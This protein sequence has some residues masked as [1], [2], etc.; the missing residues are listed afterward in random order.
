M[1]A[2][3]RRGKPLKPRV[4]YVFRTPPGVKIGR[5]PFDESVRRALEAQHPGIVFDWEKLSN[6]P[7]PSPDV[8][9]WRERRRIEKA[10]KQ[11]RREEELADAVAAGAPE[12][13]TEASADTLNVSSGPSEEPTDEIDIAVSALEA[14]GEER[15]DEVSRE[16]RTPTALPS[17]D[18]VSPPGPQS[19]TTRRRRR[20]RGGRRHRASGAPASSAERQPAEGVSPQP[21]GDASGASDQSKVPEEP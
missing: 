17:T 21:A 7:M 9:Y 6:I 20:R 5:E 11:A 3:G 1:H 16:G 10:A 8:E 12:V 13:G 18:A 19:R 2:F 15:T 14:E 4:L